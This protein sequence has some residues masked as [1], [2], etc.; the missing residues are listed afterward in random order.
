MKLLRQLRETIQVKKQRTAGHGFTLI[1]LIV[2]IAI[3]GIL[4]TIV[5]VGFSRY[6]ADTRDARRAASANV[7]AEDLEKYY[8]ANG[9]YPSCSA[10]KASSS[11]VSKQTLIGIDTK[12]LVAPQAPSGTDNSIECSSDG[13]TLTTNG[14]DFF[15]YGGDGS[16]QCNTN[17]SCLQF[18]LKYKKESTSEIVTINS[19]RNTS[20][21]TSG[22]IKNLTATATGFTS[23]NLTWQQISNATS[24]SLQQSDDAGFVTNVIPTTTTSTNASITGLVAGKTYYFRVMPIGSSGS[25]N[26]S[27]TA[28]ATTNSLA[29]P[30][31]SATTTSGTQITVTWPDIQYE[32]GYTLQY[33]SN[34]SSWTSPAP[35]TINLASGTTSYVVGG[36]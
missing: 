16:T 12:T 19:R 7:I 25:A 35:S 9:E 29:T 24:Y 30:V 22:D 5:T 3:I 1:E 20:I 34:G 26:W 33:T 8:D 11:T 18:T 6:Q 14:A 21:A 31:I 10:I 27:N 23:I 17:G 28:N 32:T 36:A 13:N 15:E 2:V 4:A